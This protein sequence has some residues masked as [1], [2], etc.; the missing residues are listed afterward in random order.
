[1]DGVAM[2]IAP[3]LPLA[4]QERLVRETGITARIVSEREQAL[5]SHIA[6]TSQISQTKLWLDC[7]RETEKL[8]HFPELFP[9]AAI[10]RHTSGTTGPSRGVVLSHRA[11]D[12]RTQACQKLLGVQEGDVVL[13]PLSISYHFIASVLTFLR[14]G[15]TILDATT[16]TPAEMLAMARTHGATMIYASPDTY[17]ALAKA[18]EAQPLPQLRRAI[19]SA[20]SLQQRTA[21]AFSETFSI[22]LTQALGIIE[23]GLPLWNET[24][25]QQSG[26]LGR[27]REPFQAR[28][29]DHGNNEVWPGET[30][31]LLISGPGLF[32]GYISSDPAQSSRHTGTWFRTGDLVRQQNDGTIAYRGRKSSVISIGTDTIV[33]EEIE[34]VIREYAEVALARVRLDLSEDGKPCIVAELVPKDSQLL[35]LESIRTICL[36]NLPAHHVPSVFRIVD[37]IPLTG[38]GKIVRHASSSSAPHR[39]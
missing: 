28:I 1:V 2:P 9:D 6:P 13:S 8:P 17:Q 39:S 22:P 18:P 4:E 3:E 16:L 14:S 25:A 29:V 38:S 30:G 20:A 21:Q 35:N 23:V 31:E 36:E 24:N 10:I 32:S 27:C 5:Y 12:Q 33:P 37:T 19:S 11:I 15:A 7:S 34:S 26:S